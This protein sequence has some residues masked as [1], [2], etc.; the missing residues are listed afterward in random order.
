MVENVTSRIE[1]CYAISYVFYC[2]FKLR[3]LT[4]SALKFYISES[5]S[6]FDLKFSQLFVKIQEFIF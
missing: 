4:F 3:Y 5:N 1:I 6:A 2:F